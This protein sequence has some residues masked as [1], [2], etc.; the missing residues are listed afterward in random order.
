MI[1]ILTSLYRSEGTV[2]EFCERAVRAAEAMGEPFE[3][4]LVNDGSTDR[5]LAEALA[6]A[7]RDP[8]IV[9]VDLSRNFGQH[10]A[11]LAGIAETKGDWIF[12]LESDLEEKP[13]WLRDFRD[14]FRRAG[15]AD[16]VYGVQAQRKGGAFERWTGQW[17]YSL[18]NLFA[19]VRIP[20]N[21][22]TCRLMTR[23]YAAA[24]LSFR[25]REL[26]LG[27]V[28]EA[29]GFKQIP[30]KVEK[31]SL[32]PTTYSLR[33]KASLVVDAMTSFSS[34]PLFSIFLAGSFFAAAAAA[35]A[36]VLLGRWALGS[37]PAGWAVAAASVWLLGGLVLMSLGVVG[38]YVRKALV[39]AKGRPRAVVRE[40]YRSAGNREQTSDNREGHRSSV[41]PDS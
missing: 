37:T 35:A 38:V 29:V 17:F 40:I 24:L 18:F 21:H 39:E 30:L 6:A 28:Y 13:E 3:I 10:P 34:A 7:A 12:C 14:A 41:R 20:E 27:G 26:F 32:S 19:D 4:V 16:V 31:L 1:S 15:D 5:S 36:V 9:V 25:E 22:V 33:R 2:R 23:R 11:L 8:R